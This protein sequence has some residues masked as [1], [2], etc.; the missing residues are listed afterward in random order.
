M[1]HQHIDQLER[2]NR[3]LSILNS[4]A[5]ALNRE[6]DLTRALNAALARVAE[7]LDLET[8][9]V[10][11]LDEEKNKF[12]PAA[13]QNL[14]P[15][16]GK[17]PR[18]LG[19]TCYCL[20][21][22]RYGDMEG[23]ANVNVIE[24]SRLENLVD[25]TD[26]LLYHA[27]IPLYAHGKQLGVLN[28]ASADW[29]ELSRDDL[30]LLYTV[31]DLISIAIE[32]AKLFASSVRLGA[33]EERNRLAREIHDTLAQRL[34]GITLQLETADALLE[35][36]AETARA[37]RVIQQTL[38]LARESI[39]DARRSVLDLRA[40]PLEGRTLPEALEKLVAET[41]EK[42]ELCTDFEVIGGGTLPARVEVGLYRIAQ[43][44]INNI[45]RHANAEWLAV[46]L[47][48]MPETVE[49]EIEDNGCGFDPQQIPGGHF[50]LTGMKERVKLL[51]GDLTIHSA[52]GVGTRIIATLPLGKKS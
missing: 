30:R 5:D 50:G 37:Q 34:A 44:A 27:S 45:L 7:L 49:L 14:P 18:R 52:L 36:G 24:C 26:G 19:G 46:Q 8:G 47:T 51:G 29:R 25:G 10:Y 38:A 13:T 35:A 15:A 11:L 40:A 42:Y 2:R 9:W 20:D 28:V 3:E 4:I 21:T 6:V 43:E 31:G 41:E 48:I 23:A 39:E 32:R 33:A 17:N 12:Y 22:Y 16:L 1:G